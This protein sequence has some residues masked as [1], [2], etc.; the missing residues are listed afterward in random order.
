MNAGDA[1]SRG[2]GVDAAAEGRRFS[3][4]PGAD[5]AGRCATD[6]FERPPRGLVRR[7]AP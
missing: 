4:R 6:F 1:D 3:G 5:T 2:T 7:T